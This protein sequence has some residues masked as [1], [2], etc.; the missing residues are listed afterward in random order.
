MQRYENYKD[1]G[2]SWIGEI[3]EHW[4]VR[5]VTHLFDKLGSGTTPTSGD[6]RF[7]DGT[8]NFLQTGDLTDGRVF[9][10]NRKITDKALK[11][12]S[13]LKIYPKGSLVM[14]MYGAT[15][16]KLGILEI[17][18]ATNQ[19]CCVFV[20]SPKVD[21]DFVFYMFFGFRKEIISMSYGG[22]QPNI[23]QDLIK[24]LRFPIPPLPEQQAIASFLDNKTEKIDR[25]IAQKEQMIALLKERKQILI[26][27]LVTG[28]KVWNEKQQAW[29]KPEKTKDS[30]VEWIGQIP[31]EWEVKR[32]RNVFRFSKGLTITKENLKEEGIPCVSYG[33]IHSK[34]GFEVDPTRHPLKK[35]DLQYLYTDINSLIGF[36]D[37]IFADTSEDLDG[38]G[39]F[40]YLNSSEKVFAG[41][42][43][44]I[45][46]PI[47]QLNSR[48]FAFEFDSQ[49][50]RNQVRKKM[51]GV[52]VFSI[53][54]SILK[55]LICWMPNSDEQRRIVEY[56]D[57]E[58]SKIDHAIS[59]QEQAIDKLKEYKTVLIDA[60]VTGKVRIDPKMEGH[61]SHSETCNHEYVG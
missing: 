38:S 1:S 21:M 6:N 52:K 17:D 47:N 14:A 33:E 16:G 3:P 20:E 58:S 36:G 42:H 51:K 7:Y 30:G 35:V 11:E 19:A 4:E 24:S 37:F 61:R 46:R 56:L 22:G 9:R 57:I 40:T 39:N 23:S 50:F 44:I 31:E 10:T 13:S 45:A 53:T 60:A 34:Y 8:I 59:L 28:K 27:D 32:L 48:F 29:T 25:A 15:I 5:K 54:Q 41:Y 43:T 12:F 2:V 49:T 18:S 26:Q 55:E